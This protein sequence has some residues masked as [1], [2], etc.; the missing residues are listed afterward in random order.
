MASDGGTSPFS[1]LSP[2]AQFAPPTTT[3]ALSDRW[4]GANVTLQVNPGP[5]SSFMLKMLPNPADAATLA[6]SV[7]PSQ[8]LPGAW[9]LCTPI[10]MSG[11]G[12]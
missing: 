6:L 5:G 11:G 12:R 7:A 1:P 3:F 9:N 10:P 8:V 2:V 4:L